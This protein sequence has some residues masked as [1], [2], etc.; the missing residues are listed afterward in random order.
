MKS[1]L[2]ECIP[3]FSDAVR[4]EVVQQIVDSIKKVG[5]INVLDL[6]SDLDHN[7]SVVTFIGNPKDVEEAAFQAIKKASL[8]IDL[9]VH[10]GAHPRIGATDVVPFV[11]IRNVTMQECVQ[12]VKHLA[13]RVSSELAIPVYL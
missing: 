1:S 5:D 7:R 2:I 9:N 12:I 6:H 8:L 3:N 11:P 4:P 13:Q 10:R